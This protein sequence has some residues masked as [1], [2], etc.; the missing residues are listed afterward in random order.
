MPDKQPLGFKSALRKAEELGK[1]IS[2]VPQLID[3]AVAK[4]DKHKNA[5]A[6]IW[7]DLNLLIQMVRAWVSGEYREVPWPTIVLIIAAI[8][9]FINPFDLFPDVIPVVG[10]VDDATVIGFVIKSLG[11]EIARFRAYKQGQSAGK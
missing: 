4:A 6:K 5:L 3:D 8:V 9:Y 10:Y 7:D 11:A 2:R 1:N